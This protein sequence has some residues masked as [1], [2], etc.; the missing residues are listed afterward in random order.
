MEMPRPSIAATGS[1]L[2]IYYLAC[3]DDTM[4]RICGMPN[5]TLERLVKYVSKAT[6]DALDFR[7]AWIYIRSFF[8]IRYPSGFGRISGEMYDK[9][10]S[11]LTSFY[12]KTLTSWL[13]KINTTYSFLH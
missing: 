5:Q 10:W 2:C 9:V 6:W 13:D 8:N 7:L 4:E 11:F 3:D 12:K 1:S